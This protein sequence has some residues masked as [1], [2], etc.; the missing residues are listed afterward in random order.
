M[1][2][3]HVCTMHFSIV[4][5]PTIVEFHAQCDGRHLT[6]AEVMDAIHS[7]STDKLATFFPGMQLGNTKPDTPDKVD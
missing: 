1:Y 6:N 2:V 4:P 3:T 7:L 5:R